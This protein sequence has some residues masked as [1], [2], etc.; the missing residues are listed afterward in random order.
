MEYGITIPKGEKYLG[1]IS[2]LM[3]KYPERCSEIGR[4]IVNGLLEEYRLIDVRIGKLDK[5]FESLG[6]AHPVCRRLQMIPGVGPIISTAIVA[7]SP[8]ATNF[9]NGRE[10][11]AW[12]GLVPKQ[13]SSGGKA[14]LLGISKRG[15]VY[16]R[17]QLV[18]GARAVLRVAPKKTDKRSLWIESVKKRRGWNK[19]SVAMA[20]KNARTI[21]ALMRYENEYVVT[22]VA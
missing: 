8:P 12:L 17:K 5:Q 18:H 6:K 16:L 15:D 9:K 11:A 13:S 14:R 22:N 1:T 10:F 3:E 4:Q 19:A 2:E 20:N 7:A 21:W